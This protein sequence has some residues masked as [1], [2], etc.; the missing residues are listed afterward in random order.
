MSILQQT[1]FLNREELHSVDLAALEAD[2]SL[3]PGFFKIGRW[4]WG[5]DP[6]AYAAMNYAA[7][8]DHL[9]EDKPFSN[10]NLPPGHKYTP[11]TVASEMKRIADGIPSTLKSNGYWGL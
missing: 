11:W 3:T 6:Q 10:T 4:V 5:H 9:R 2:P 8:L 7:C 1:G